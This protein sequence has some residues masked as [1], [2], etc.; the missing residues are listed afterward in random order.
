MAAV[1]KTLAQD[2]FTTLSTLY[3]VPTDKEAVCFITV[4]AIGSTVRDFTL[5][6]APGGAADSATHYIADA[7]SIPGNDTFIFPFPFYLDDGD[8]IRCFANSVNCAFNVNGIEID[9]LAGIQ[10]GVLAQAAPGATLTDMY[11]VPASTE[12]IAYLSVAN[13]GATASIAM[14][15][16]PLGAADNDDQFLLD[17]MTVEANDTYLHPIPIMMAPTDK[18]RIIGASDNRFKFTLTGMELT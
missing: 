9:S 14:K 11:T 7:I 6:I 3:T 12:A 1:Y 4:A 8:I 17:S 15:L 5:K 18:L 2:R 13:A 16:A 10:R